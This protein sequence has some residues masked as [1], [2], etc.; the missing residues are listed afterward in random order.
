MNRR[1][2]I[3]LAV[4]VGYLAFIATSAATGFSP[5]KQ[6]GSNF[7]YFWA[8]LIK[9]LPFAFVLIGL[10]EVW[11]DRQTVERHLG[12]ESGAGGY[13]WA[14]VLSGIT[15][16][17]VFVAFPVA[18]SLHKKGAALGVIFTYIGASAVCRI[19]M[20]LFE[21]SFMGPKFTAIR[22]AVSLPLVILSSAM[23]GR[24]L[25]KQ[26]YQIQGG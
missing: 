12:A 5:G 2:W 10:F 26:N 8:D 24:Y 21:L 4:L 1:S 11:V 15:V 19:P 25:E 18:H 3:K 9:V 17:G 13:L 20:N 16:G 7:I 14:I 23:L 6:I 22:L